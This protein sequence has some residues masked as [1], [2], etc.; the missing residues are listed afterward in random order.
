MIE[1]NASDARGKADA[2]PL[3]GVNGKTANRIK[4]LC[5]NRSLS[6]AFGR[7]GRDERGRDV[8]AF[9]KTVRRRA[10]IICFFFF[11]FINIFFFF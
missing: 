9:A 8:G 2:D 6:D 7:G 11:H 4:E 3:K 5:T 10:R 1:V